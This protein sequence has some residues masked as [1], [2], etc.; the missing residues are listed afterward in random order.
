[1]QVGGMRSLVRVEPDATSVLSAGEQ[2][3]G[4]T[5]PGWL[6]WSQVRVVEEALWQEGVPAPP[7]VSQLRREAREAAAKQE[8]PQAPGH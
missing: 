7:C 1:M 8:M 5:G 3:M 4:R 2:A 6:R